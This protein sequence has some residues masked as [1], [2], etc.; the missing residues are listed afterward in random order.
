MST[1]K[2][3]ELFYDVV[4]P[5]SWLGFEVLLRYKTIWNVDIHLRPGFLGAIIGATANTPPAMI[6]KKFTYMMQDLDKVAEFYQVPLRQP[7][8]FFHVILKKGSLSAMRFVTA[9][10][11]S[12]PEFLEQLSRELWLR[13]WSEDKDITEPESILQ[14]AKKAGIPEDLGKK[15]LS[16]IS[17]PEVKNKLRENTDQ[18]LGYGIFGMPSIVAH[19]NEKP[20]MFF[21]SDRFELLA[22]RIGEKWLGPVPQR[23]QL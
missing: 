16:T 9:V 1:R 2:V 20:E 12:H 7:S 14:A 4:S 11:M 21:G 19:I 6:P 18:A 23:S 5:Y 10:Q 13:I 17:S 3:L 15:L 8:D 22:H